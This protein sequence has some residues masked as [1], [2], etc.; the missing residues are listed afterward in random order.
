VLS[1]TGSFWQEICLEERKAKKR[2]SSEERK[3]QKRRKDQKRRKAQKMQAM[4]LS[5]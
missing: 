2:E 4:L 3:A 1:E 5:E